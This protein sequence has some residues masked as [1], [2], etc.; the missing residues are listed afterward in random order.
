M[1]A[2]DV[3]NA[4]YGITIKEGLITATEVVLVG[5]LNGTYP[6]N[7]AEGAIDSPSPQS[8]PS[9]PPAASISVPT[10]SPV[11]GGEDQSASAGETTNKSLKAM[12][13]RIRVDGLPSTP[14]NDHGDDPY[15]RRRNLAMLSVPERQPKNLRGYHNPLDR[16]Q[17]LQ[18]SSRSLVYYTEERPVVITDV[19]D[20]LDQAC[21]QGEVCMEVKS[22]I[23]VTLE[24]DDVADEIEAV[25]RSEFQK[26]LEDA[27]FFAVSFFIRR[28]GPRLSTYGWLTFIYP[29]LIT[30]TSHSLCL[31]IPLFV[32]R[33]PV[34]LPRQSP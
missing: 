10:M 6:Q 32:H 14:L 9:M 26:S 22:T 30:S 3:M 34:P 11:G 2:Y 33:H 29:I 1:T 24:E 20:V 4:N 15:Y 23:F 28:G 31:P 5:I 21:P 13:I 8:I 7:T 12:N 25:I 18:R 19:E 16:Q 27:S 17:L